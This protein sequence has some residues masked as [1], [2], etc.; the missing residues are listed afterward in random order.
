MSDASRQLNRRIYLRDGVEVAVG[1][2]LT[3]PRLT[4][5]YKSTLSRCID[6][7]VEEAILPDIFVFELARLTVLAAFEVDED[8]IAP[9]LD[10]IALESAV[11]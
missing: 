11:V 4:L 9:P 5:S 1:S 10:V 7:C 8:P 3:G 6:F 2:I